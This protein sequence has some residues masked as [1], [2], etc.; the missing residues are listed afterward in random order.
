[1]STD[2]TNS[3]SSR[4]GRENQFK[5]LTSGTINKTEWLKKYLLKQGILVNSLYISGIIEELNHM[6]RSQQLL[7]ELTW[8]ELIK[9]MKKSYQT[10]NY[11][12][13]KPTRR[14]VA[15]TLS[16]ECINSIEKFAKSNK[17][18]KNLAVEELINDNFNLYFEKYKKLKHQ[19]KIAREQNKSIELIE[20]K[21]TLKGEIK[22]LE[23]VIKYK[24]KS[25]EL[26]KIELDFLFKK[27][28]SLA[29]EKK[30]IELDEFLEIQEK[31][32]DCISRVNDSCKYFS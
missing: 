26:M 11:R 23:S 20:I 5:F 25:I 7:G 31:Y 15:I 18:T 1:M 9:K 4:R 8:E 13:S 29:Y 24:D 27:L 17:I 12:A 3:G 19:E 32:F 6:R 10:A 16:A 21:G 30:D 28:T 22:K 14:T 2:I